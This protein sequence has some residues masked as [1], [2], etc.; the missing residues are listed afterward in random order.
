MHKVAVLRR[1]QPL[2]TLKAQKADH[3]ISH[4][5]MKMRSGQYV[6]PREHANRGRGI[7]S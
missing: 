4:T 7:R 2:L 5:G 1:S 3:Y 6:A